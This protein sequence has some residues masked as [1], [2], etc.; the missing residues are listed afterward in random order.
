MICPVLKCV[1]SPSKICAVLMPDW[2][3]NYGA[4][5]TNPVVIKLWGSELFLKA[6]IMLVHLKKRKKKKSFV[7]TPN[8]EIFTDLLNPK[9]QD[10]R[11]TQVW[12]YVLKGS[13]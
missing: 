6:R 10:L 7:F 3:E 12:V 13:I 9:T 11:L 2:Y 1:K 4:L 5:R 8:M